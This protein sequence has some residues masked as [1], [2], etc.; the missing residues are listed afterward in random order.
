MILYALV[1]Y[2]VGKTIEFFGTPEE[3]EQTLAT[4]LLDEPA[5]AEEPEIVE[6]DFGEFAQPN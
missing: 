4:G 2:R 3:A 6:T 5:W 1:D